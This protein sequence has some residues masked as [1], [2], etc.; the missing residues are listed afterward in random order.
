MSLTIGPL[1]N[2]GLVS[3]EHGQLIRK[4]IEKTHYKTGIS[5]L[6]D[7]NG[8]RPSYIHFVLGRTSG[9]KSTLVR[10]MI[11]DYIEANRHEENNQIYV[12]LSEEKVQD[13]QAALLATGI[14]FE[15]L[16]KFVIFSSELDLPHISK[17]PISVIKAVLAEHPNVGLFVYDNITTSR[18]YT[19]LKPSDQ[20][21]FVHHL[22]TYISTTDIACVLVGHT[23]AQA[24]KSTQLL[25]TQDVMG[26]KGV[27]NLAEFYYVM[28]S[29]YANNRRY[30]FV[31]TLKHRGYS[32]D[33]NTYAMYYSDKSKTFFNSECIDFKA[34]A[35]ISKERDKI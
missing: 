30:N 31:R 15:Q 19:T 8:L 33:K 7:H 10:T 29:F 1:T 25:T 20:F 32:I 34:L 22:K 5:F 24:D 21:D 27:A 11:H 2:S 4:E 23:N 35:A 6:K 18:L 13:Y 16:K 3:Q 9:G 12:Y 28:E 14:T 17:T 26:S